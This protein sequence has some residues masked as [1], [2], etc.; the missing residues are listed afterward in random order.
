[1]EAEQ[2]NQIEQPNQAPA[3]EQQPN[4]MS[5]QPIDAHT[6]DPIQPLDTPA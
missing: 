6:E 2:P 5:N 1:M 3:K 4:Q